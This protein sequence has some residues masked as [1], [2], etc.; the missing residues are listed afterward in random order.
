MFFAMLYK[1]IDRAFER[2][3]HVAILAFVK[4]LEGVVDIAQEIIGARQH[5]VERT[6]ET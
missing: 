4:I 1:G 2:R 3:H 5:V 6:P